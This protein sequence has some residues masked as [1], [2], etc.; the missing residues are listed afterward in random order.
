MPR[1]TAPINQTKMSSVT[2]IP[3]PIAAPAASAPDNPAWLSTAPFV[4][5]QIEKTINILNPQN[6]N[7]MS[8]PKMPR[9]DFLST[10][11]HDGH[12]VALVLTLCS[13]VGH[14][15]IRGLAT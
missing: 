15:I 12:D 13:Q 14:S 1:M 2:P 3:V 7:I 11:P 8:F 5:A 4:P 10:A 6:A 9:F